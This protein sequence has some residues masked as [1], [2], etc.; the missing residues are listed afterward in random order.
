MPGVIRSASSGDVASNNS[1]N[2]DLTPPSPP[3]S[4]YSTSSSQFTPITRQKTALFRLQHTPDKKKENS[5]RNASF[6]GPK[7]EGGI[8]IGDEHQAEIPDCCP[9]ACLTEYVDEEARGER[10]SICV[11]KPVDDER[12]SDERIEEFI[13]AALVQNCEFNREQVLG[14]LYEAEMDIDR[15]MEKMEKYKPLASTLSKRDQELFEQ[16]FSFYGKNFRRLKVQFP[17]NRWP[18]WSPSITSRRRSVN[19]RSVMCNKDF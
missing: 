1:S 9:L 10:Q 8:R 12:I 7:P 15:A 4:Q 14:V 16:T 13:K 6:L 11:W 18:I 5:N 17:E 2:S 3:S 19:V